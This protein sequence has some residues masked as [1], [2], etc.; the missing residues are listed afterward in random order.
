MQHVIKSSV[1]KAEGFI[2]WSDTW[3][4]AD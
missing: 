3:Q 2:S 4:D 1:L